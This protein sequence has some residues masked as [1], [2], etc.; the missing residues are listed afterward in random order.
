MRTQQNY[1]TRRRHFVCI[2][3]TPMHFEYFFQLALRRFG[4][5]F[6]LTIAY[7]L[8]KNMRHL[9]A[10]SVAPTKKTLTANYQPPTRNYKK[11]WI[12]IKP[13]YWGKLYQMRYFMGYSMSCILRILLEWEMIEEGIPIQ[14]LVAKPPLELHLGSGGYQNQSYYRS[15]E[16][17]TSVN[18]EKLEVTNDF[19]DRSD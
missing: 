11:N 5:D 19:F 14:P 13:P 12:D 15:Y 1:H 17:K 3:L 4:G 7:L 10:I 18:Y 2:N 8:N 16:L 6:S 9:Y